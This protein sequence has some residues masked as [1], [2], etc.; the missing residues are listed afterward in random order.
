MIDALQKTA[1]LYREGLLCGPE[2][3][4]KRSAELEERIHAL[5]DGLT[6]AQK[7]GAAHAA[8][9]VE[10][11]DPASYDWLHLFIATEYSERGQ[12]S[13]ALFE[14]DKIRRYGIWQRS[15][16]NLAGVCEVEANARL[17]NGDIEG[18]IVAAERALALEPNLPA[19]ISVLS[20]A[21]GLLG[22]EEESRA[23]AAKIDGARQARD[24]QRRD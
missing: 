15:N 8:E 17:K 10:A 13:A 6:E 20:T 18:A 2:A 12:L 3:A 14:L 21:H 11:A 19:V 7:A 4:E 23:W 22:H 24:G 16:R 1:T 5:R 9:S